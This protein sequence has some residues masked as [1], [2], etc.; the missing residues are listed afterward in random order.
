MEI[1]QSISICTHA[2]EAEWLRESLTAAPSPSHLRALTRFAVLATRRNCQARWCMRMAIVT[3]YT[4]ED[5][6][7]KW[8]YSGYP[9][10]F[11]SSMPHPQLTSEATEYR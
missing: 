9:H 8:A 6:F 4:L 7:Q 3:N 11:I 5:A 2:I 1:F 10:C